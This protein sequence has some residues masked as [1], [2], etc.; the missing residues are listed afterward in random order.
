MISGM[1]IVIGVL[2]RR[3]LQSQ[4]VYVEVFTVEVC[5]IISGGVP[6]K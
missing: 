5:F 4:S 6:G 3:D 2:V 1:R